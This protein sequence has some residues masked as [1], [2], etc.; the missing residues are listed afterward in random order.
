MQKDSMPFATFDRTR[1]ISHCHTPFDLL[2]LVH[3]EWVQKAIGKWQ[4]KRIRRQTLIWD[5]KWLTKRQ[6][7]APTP[8]AIADGNW[9]KSSADGADNLNTQSING[10]YLCVAR[11]ISSNAQQSNKGKGKGI[12][13]FDSKWPEH[14][15]SKSESDCESIKSGIIWVLLKSEIL[16]VCLGWAGRAW[17]ELTRVGLGGCL[18][19]LDIFSHLSF[20]LSS[21]SVS[22]RAQHG[23]ST[24]ATFL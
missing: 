23:L 24:D 21:L 19:L 12:P 7:I 13:R 4:K 16:F 9:L 20:S 14:R 17:G 10:M 1:G 22:C 5:G 2:A 6:R 3:F 18:M 8:S 11:V 15:L